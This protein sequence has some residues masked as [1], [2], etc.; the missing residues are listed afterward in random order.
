MSSEVKALK[1]S[2]GVRESIGT[3]SAVALR[4]SGFVPAVLYDGS[5]GSSVHLFV[6]HKE[7]LSLRKSSGVLANRLFELNVGGNTSH[8]ILKEIQRHVVTDEVVHIDFQK[9]DKSSKVRVEIAIKIVGE[10]ACDGLR[11]GGILNFALRS[12][13]LQCNPL[14]IPAII[15]VDISALQIGDSIHVKDVNLPSG[16][17]IAPGVDPIAPVVSVVPPS[18]DEKGE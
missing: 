10:D 15:E 9:V 14:A 6:N 4:R 17:S 12:V 16:V 3:S 1:I 5:T 8:A 13:R 7:F 2:C 11:G 18:D